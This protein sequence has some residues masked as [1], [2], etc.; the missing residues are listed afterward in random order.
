MVNTTIEVKDMK[1]KIKRFFID[2]KELIIFLSVV[3]VVFSTVIVIASLALK[4][5]PVEKPLI[6]E[7][8]PVIQ[9]TDNNEQPVIT[10][11]TF[12]L[13][14][15]GEYEV[16]RTFFDPSLPDEQLVDAIINNGSYMIESKGVSY[17]KP[18]NSV[19]DVTC[20]YEGQVSEIIDDELY[21]I[22]VSIKHADGV[23]SIYSSLSDVN[24]VVNESVS[25]GD[26]IGK[27][28]SSVFDSEAGNHVHLEVTVDGNY[29]DPNSIMGKELSEI[30]NDK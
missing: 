5:Q 24:L 22:T 6:T 10:I 27:A 18:D 13:P 17:S 7:E 11:P 4:E 28:A 3:L 14:I 20:I 1:N 19:F 30:Q 21:G 8:P 16:V 2:K 15:N 29:V 25:K 12:A 23:Y 26:V 9:Q